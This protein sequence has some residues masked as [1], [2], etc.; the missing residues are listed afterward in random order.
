[1]AIA[2][3]KACGEPHPV[4]WDLG[5]GRHQ[6]TIVGRSL[7]IYRMLHTHYIYIYTYIC[8]YICI[9][10]RYTICMCAMC[11][12]EIVLKWNNCGAC[13]LV[14]HD[15]LTLAFET[16]GFTSKHG[17]LGRLEQLQLVYMR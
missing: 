10:Y 12:M 8:I 1:M 2:G 6:V 4:P 16:D 9:T 14:V 5:I 17:F 15:S 13:Q 11:H 7:M 3:P